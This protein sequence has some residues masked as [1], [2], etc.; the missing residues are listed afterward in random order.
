MVINK[1]GRSPLGAFYRSPLG[2]RTRASGEGTV[3]IENQGYMFILTTYA[4]GIDFWNTEVASFETL[5]YDMSA[6]PVYV[7]TVGAGASPFPVG[8][9]YPANLENHITHISW[10]DP[11]LIATMTADWDAL[12][13]LIPPAIFVASVYFDDSVNHWESPYADLDFYVQGLGYGAGD[14]SDTKWLEKLRNT[15]IPA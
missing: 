7:C 14:Y 1:A 3:A 2:V 9:S 6:C 13:A 15:I 10:P 8:G 4:A 5:D 11:P 12:E